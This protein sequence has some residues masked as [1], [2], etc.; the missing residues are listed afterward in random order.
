MDLK[1]ILISLLIGAV[2]GWLASILM[3]KKKSLIVNII[4]G[5]IGGFVG[6][7]LFGIL[8][9]SLGL[10]G[11]LGDI[12]VSTIGACIFIAILNLLF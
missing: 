11:I 4:L 5:I 8:G 6:S 3:G 7:W 9:I 12:V 1:S 2:A 10:S